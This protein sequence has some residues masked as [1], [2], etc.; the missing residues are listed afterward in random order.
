MDILIISAENNILH[1]CNE[2]YKADYTIYN[3]KGHNLDGGVLESSKGR[4]N[5]N[6]I[7]NEIMSIIKERF[8][9]SKPYIRLKGE[10]CESLLELI[11]AEDYKHTQSKMK[12]L[13]SSI[14]DKADLINEEMEHE[15]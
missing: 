6:N 12:E 5:D 1:I 13:L 15:K 11:E 10:D 9:F 4:L 7:S 3:S 14:Q 2:G 8:S